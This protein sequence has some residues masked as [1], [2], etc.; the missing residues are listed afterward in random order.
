[1]L[2]FEQS[3][4]WDHWTDFNAQY[5]KTRVSAGRATFGSQ[6]NNFTITEGQNTQK[7]PKIGPNRERQQLLDQAATAIGSGRRRLTNLAPILHRS[8]I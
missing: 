6:N 3:Y 7:L 5:L 4:R 8:E 1:M 2:I